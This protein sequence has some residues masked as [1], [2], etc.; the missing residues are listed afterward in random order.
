VS[1]GNGNSRIKRL[2]I[3]AQRGFKK[4]LQNQQTSL[5]AL[6]LLR[7]TSA[8]SL[9]FLGTILAMGLMK[10]AGGLFE[11]IGFQ[12]SPTGDFSIHL[13]TWRF[14]PAK[15]DSQKAIASLMSGLEFF[16]L[17]PLAYLLLRSLGNYVESTSLDERGLA[18]AETTSA[19][20]SVKALSTGLLIAVL[21]THL[22]AEFLQEHEDAMF[23]WIKIASGIG[24]LSI[25]VGYFWVL[26]KL[27]Q[28]PNHGQKPSQQAPLT[29]IKRR[30]MD[31]GYSAELERVSEEPTGQNDGDSDHPLV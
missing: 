14:D 30:E 29:E 12:F 17:A 9:F 31:E 6:F 1:A 4:M 25:L 16:L 20:R 5:F 27:C 23:P 8:A 26:E 7:L 2:L 13:L 22:T 24:L 3:R 15:A 18:D 11:F 10:M 28:H 21:A 19:L